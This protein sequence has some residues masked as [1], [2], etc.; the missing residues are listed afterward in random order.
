[1]IEQF[2]TWI[3]MSFG[4]AIILAFIFVVFVVIPYALV[5]FFSKTIAAYKTIG[6]GRIELREGYSRLGVSTRWASRNL[7]ATGCCL[8]SGNRWLVSLYYTHP[9]KW[10]I[11]NHW[12]NVSDTEDSEEAE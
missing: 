2:F 11:V 6:V 8:H 12:D 9:F 1:M 10:K 4:A 7:L 3:G 5:D